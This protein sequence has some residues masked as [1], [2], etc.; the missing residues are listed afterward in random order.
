MS[1]RIDHL[2]IT[3]PT[4]AIGGAF[5]FEQL[6]VRLNVG[7][8]HPRMGTHN[9]LLRLGDTMFLEVIAINPAAAQTLRARW[10]E[11]D[12]QPSEPRLACWVARA[13]DIRE[14]VTVAS[15]ALGIIEPMSRGAIE[16]LISVPEDGSLPLGGI[17]PAL[18]QWQSANHPA[19]N[20]QDQG[21][22]LVGLDLLHPDPKRVTELL[23]S[24]AIAEPGVSLRVREASAPRLVAHINTPL[25][26]RTLGAPQAP[27][28]G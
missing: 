6:G 14:S 20:M 15:E 8:E 26:L 23:R 19:Q 11:L 13:D 7:G 17:G 2:I 1:C 28:E 9:L 22:Q 4:L 5:A 27:F 10:F 12:A 24:L 21:C 18:I 3:A 25:G 16:W